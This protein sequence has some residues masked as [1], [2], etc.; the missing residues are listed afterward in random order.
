MIEKS[1][2]RLRAYNDWRIGK[3]ERTMEEAGITPSQI[4]IDLQNVLNELEKLIKMRDS[5]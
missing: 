1:I 5:E 4:T 3:D 2:E